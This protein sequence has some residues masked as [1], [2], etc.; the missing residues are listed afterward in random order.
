MLCYA[1][2][3]MSSRVSL[4]E[5]LG[6]AAAVILPGQRPQGVVYD[7]LGQGVVWR[8]YYGYH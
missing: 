3:V 2:E 5:M 6:T 1:V 7:T 8:V 4:V